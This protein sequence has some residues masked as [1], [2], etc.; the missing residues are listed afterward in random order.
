MDKLVDLIHIHDD[1]LSEEDCSFLINFF[2]IN[3]LK[4]ERYD[5]DGAP[6]FTQLNITDLRSENE[7]LNEIHERLVKKIFENSE[8]YYEY[9]DKRVFPSTCFLE[10]FRIKRYNT[11]GIDRFDTH[12]DIVDRRSSKRY[13]SITFYL[14][15][16]EEGGKTIFKD[17]DIQPKRG[18][19]MLF[20]PMWMYPHKGE[21]P[22][23]NTKYI[24]T[25]YFHYN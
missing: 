13:L 25:T 19:M 20:P 17:I 24:L 21:P 2:E 12:V 4:H 8:K 14:N 7:K 9:V 3:Q 16:I 1:T 10:K 22:I 23:S 11:D 15:D 18:R 6:N 5:N